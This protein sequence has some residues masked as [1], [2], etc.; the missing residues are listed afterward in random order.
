MRYSNRAVLIALIGIALI[1]SVVGY[2][3]GYRNAAHEAMVR[4]QEEK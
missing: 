3:I 1:A 2:S 4:I